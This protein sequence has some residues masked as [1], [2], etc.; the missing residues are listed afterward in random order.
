MFGFRATVI[1]NRSNR[2]LSQFK[3]GNFLKRC[4]ENSYRYQSELPHLP[5]PSVENSINRYLRSLQAQLGSGIS[6]ND[7]KEAN[8]LTKVERKTCHY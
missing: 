8:N 6:E 4:D 5:I 1:L 2:C 7:I 3:T